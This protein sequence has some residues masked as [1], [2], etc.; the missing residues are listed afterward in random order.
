MP[1]A[2]LPRLT[3]ACIVSLFPHPPGV[4]K[5]LSLKGV[6]GFAVCP[7]AE[8]PLIAAYVPEAK[9]SPG[10]IALYDYSAISAGGDAPPPLC[11][12]SFYRVRAW[13]GDGRWQVAE[14][15]LASWRAGRQAGEQ[16][17]GVEV[18]RPPGRCI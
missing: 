9:G 13:V 12:K 3:P 4:S 17:G 1:P 5:R 16:Q 18:S 7:A 6:A 15:W 8:R 14:G 2:C 10:F 11:R